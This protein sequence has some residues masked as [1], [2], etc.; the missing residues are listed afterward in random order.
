[1]PVKNGVKNPNVKLFN[2]KEGDIDPYQFY[3]VADI[4]CDYLNY[5]ISLNLKGLVMTP[6]FFSLLSHES[7]IGHVTHGGPIE[8]TVSDTITDT[9]LNSKKNTFLEQ[10]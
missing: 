4:G 3:F 1:M 8:L 9:G 5:T 10:L 7:N 6:I 2:L